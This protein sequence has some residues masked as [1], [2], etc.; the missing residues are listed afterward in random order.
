MKNYIGYLQNPGLPQGPNELANLDSL[1][2]HDERSARFPQDFFKNLALKKCSVFLQQSKIALDG[3]FYKGCFVFDLEKF[4]AR[5]LSDCF[6]EMIKPKK[7]D[8][9]NESAKFFGEKDFLGSWKGSLTLKKT[10]SSELSESKYSKIVLTGTWAENGWKTGE[11]VEEYFMPTN[12]PEQPD[13]LVC[14]LKCNYADD[15][16]T[17]I[18]VMVLDSEIICSFGPKFTITLEKIDAKKSFDIVI[19]VYRTSELFWDGKS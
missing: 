14:S 18:G 3:H 5:F 2:P 17:C 19:K 16:R 12:Q 6:D 8:L 15:G 7:I 13:Q 10:A 1:S 11:F 9:E 4:T